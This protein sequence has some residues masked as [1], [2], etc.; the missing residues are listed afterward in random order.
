MSLSTFPL[1]P[2]LKVATTSPLLSFEQEIV[3]QQPAIEQWFRQQWIKTPAPFYCSCDLRNAGYKLAPVDTNLFPAGFNNLSI[4]SEAIAIHSLQVSVERYCPDACDVLII[5][6]AHTRNLMYL[7]G[8]CRLRDMLGKAGFGVRIANLVNTE[9]TTI[10]LPSGKAISIHPLQKKANKIYVEDF[11]PCAIVLNNDFSSGHPELLDGVQQHILPNHHL[12]WQNR[13]KSQH[14]SEYTKTA[15]NFAQLIGIDPWLISPQ[16]KISSGISFKTGAGIEELVGKA[17]EIL[18]YTRTKYKQY[19]IKQDPYVVVK[20]NT[21]TYG[22]GVMTIKNT[23][24]LLNTNRK[25]RNKM[26]VGKEGV[27]IDELLVQEGIPTF[28]TIGKDKAVAEPVVY[29]I[30]HYVVGGFYRIHKS[31]GIDENLNA[32][33]MIFEPLDFSSCLGSKKAS[34]DQG[35]NHFYVY[36][37]IAR[38]ALLAAA[39]EMENCVPHPSHIPPPK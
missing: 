21:G 19:G 22:M 33:G 18:Q 16:Q 27:V 32:P 37:V 14:F 23:Q 13:T 25:Q 26:S 11:I 1:V 17:D 10:S 38:L 39:Q 36:G 9:V 35:F 24:Q 28:E 3:N 5:A 8:L 34:R 15:T 2:N 6:E 30:D 12:G 29:M 31:R 20:A 7:E 4:D